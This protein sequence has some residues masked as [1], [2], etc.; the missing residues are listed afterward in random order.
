M[1]IKAIETEED[2]TAAFQRLE[3][4]FQ[5]DDG[6][7]EAVEMEALVIQIE[8]FESKCYPIELKGQSKT[9]EAG[10]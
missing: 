9:S 8:A 6:T 2:L 7:P 10:G 4:I 1:D 3:Q 5:A